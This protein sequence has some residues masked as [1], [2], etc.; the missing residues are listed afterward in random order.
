MTD[1]HQFEAF[2]RAYQNMVFTTA[3]RLLGNESEAQDVA[4]EV[5]LKAYERFADLQ[6]SPTAGGWLKTVATNLC[7][8]HLTRYR[9]RWTLFSEM[10]PNSDE[11]S[12]FA[13]QIPAADHLDEALGI[14]NR[15][16]LE[17]ALQ[18]LPATQRVPLVLYHFQEMSY[19]NIAAKL[20]ISLSKVKTDIHRGRTALAR[21]LERNSSGEAVPRPAS[22]LG[23]PAAIQR[24]KHA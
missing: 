19:E 12:H 6:T 18:Q 2:M 10:T 11:E 23:N 24:A 21:K 20:K 13:E 14:D 8:N 1:T 9:A 4:Q 3:V 22:G 5:F 15:Q 7:L 16:L 17:S